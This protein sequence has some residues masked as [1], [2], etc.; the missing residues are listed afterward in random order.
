MKSPI[1]QAFAD[2]WD[3]LLLDKEAETKWKFSLKESLMRGQATKLLADYHVHLIVSNMIDVLK[4]VCGSIVL[5]IINRLFLGAIETCG[6]KCYT[7]TPS[8]GTL[9]K[10]IIVSTAENKSKYNK[11]LKQNP[12]PIIVTPEAIFDGVL[13]QELHLEDH[14]LT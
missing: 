3:H 14:V 12:K 7:R 5:I 4:G 11:F 10:Y 1:K 6:G 2:P 13:R 9:G 8:K